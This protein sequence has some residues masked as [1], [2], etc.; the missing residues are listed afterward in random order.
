MQEQVKD[1]IHITSRP[2]RKGSQARLKSLWPQLNTLGCALLVVLVFGILIL[3]LID[4]QEIYA[5]TLKTTGTPTD[6][7]ENSKTTAKATLK[8]DQG[9]ITFEASISTN[10]HNTPILAHVHEGGSPTGPIL[11]MLHGETDQSGKVDLGPQS[12]S[13]A[14]G[15]KTN[16][17]SLPSSIPTDWFFNVHDANVIDPATND[18]VSLGSAPF[19]ANSKGTSAKASF[20]TSSV[21]FSSNIVPTPNSGLSQQDLRDLA[22]Q[23]DEKKMLIQQLQHQIDTVNIDIQQIQHTLDEHKFNVAKF[24][25]CIKDHPVSQC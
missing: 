20:T 13:I 11:L 15:P 6:T 21:T 16:G 8:D 5:A 23:V 2:T 7:Q 9:T 4:H 19:T 17:Q 18:P 12:F 24:E 10:L 25:A 1:E 22:R 14:N 3:Q